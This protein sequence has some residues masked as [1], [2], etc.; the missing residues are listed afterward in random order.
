M[1]LDGSS[2]FW[3]APMATRFVAFDVE[4]TGLFVERGHGIIEIGAVVVNGDEMGEEFQSLICCN[5]PISK[6]A[7]KVHSITSDM[8][9][10]Q[11]VV[12]EVMTRFREFV[13]TSPLVGH[14]AAFDVGFLQ[15]ECG[16]ADVLLTCRYR[17][18]LKMSRSRY[19]GLPNYKLETVAR[20]LGIVVDETRRHR[21]L[22]DARLTAKVWIEMTMKKGTG[23]P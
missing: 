18:T 6:A 2:Y 1:T 4:T 10:G 22:D 8:L 7:R 20:R 3:T 16:R 17:C 5:A 13:S 15:R 19:P 23:K 14:N 12:R 21:A 9:A 11:P